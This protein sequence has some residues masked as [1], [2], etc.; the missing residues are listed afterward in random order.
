M[1]G[2]PSSGKPPGAAGRARPGRRSRP[3]GAAG[4]GPESGRPVGGGRRAQA[5]HRRPGAAVGLRRGARRPGRGRILGPAAR[6]PHGQPRGHLSG[7]RRP[8]EARMSRRQTDVVAAD[9]G[10]RILEPGYRPYRGVRLGVG[11][12]VWALAR[13]TTER[14]MGLRRP[15][16]YKVLPFAVGSHRLPAGDR[17]HRHRGRSYPTGGYGSRTSFP[18]QAAITVLSLRRSSSSPRWPRRRPFAPTSARA[19][20]AS[21][22]PLR[23]T[24]RPTCWPKPSP[25]LA[26]SCSSP[27]D[28]RCCC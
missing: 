14:I 25:W 10:A 12:S 1:G 6:A 21:T 7:Q 15:A 27:S 24:V 3:V 4:L 9:G 13:H 23:S 5:G 19:F 8:G 2:S 18:D 11:H 16:R 20:S 22:W 26:F 17:V 28:R